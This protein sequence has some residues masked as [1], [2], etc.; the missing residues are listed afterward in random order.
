MLA[1]VRHKPD[2]G[3]APERK[4]R[5]LVVD[6]DRLILATLEDGLRNAGF[7][8][9]LA[10]SGLEAMQAAMEAPPD[11]AIIDVRMTGMDGIEFAKHLR[12]HTSI[13]FVFLSAYGD[14]ALV[15]SAIDQGALG[16]LLKPIDIPQ[17]IPALEAALARGR[18]IA[19]LREAE[20]RLKA[21][22]S[23][24]QKTRT[25]VGVLMERRRLDQQAAFDALRRHAR[26]QRRKIA[27]IAEEVLNSA[28]KLN[29]PVDKVD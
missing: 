1:E 5:V 15:R 6:D 12:E 18:E 11:V 16:Y 4:A 24:E 8:V 14:L 13:P 7:E 3:P 28:E 22:L 10:A 26:S 21:A 25:A 23:T 2:N 17:L 27:E 29:F 9:A 19:R 20:A